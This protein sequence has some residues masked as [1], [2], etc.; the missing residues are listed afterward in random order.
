MSGILFLILGLAALKITAWQSGLLTITTGGAP[1]ETD[2]TI[3]G[4]SFTA[5]IIF[6]GLWFAGKFKKDKSQSN[7]LF[8]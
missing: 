6:F 5:A 1:P 2:Y 4:L 3:V 8:E 7:S